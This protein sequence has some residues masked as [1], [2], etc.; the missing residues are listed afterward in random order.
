MA[1]S[2]RRTWLDR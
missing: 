2:N 1:K